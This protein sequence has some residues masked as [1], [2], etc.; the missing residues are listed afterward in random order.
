MKTVFLPKSKKEISRFMDDISYE[1]LGQDFAV[2]EEEFNAL[3]QSDIFSKFYRATN[4]LIDDFEM[5][6]VDSSDKLTSFLSILEKE[7]PKGKQLT[8][9]IQKFTII[10][11]LAIKE[12]SALMFFF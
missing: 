5:T 12:D 2:S 9:V 10:T 11:K 1:M 8:D 6:L 3:W 7:A 4:I